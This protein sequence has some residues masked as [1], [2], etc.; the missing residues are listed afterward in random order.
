M[1]D[2]ASHHRNRQLTPAPASHLGGVPVRSDRGTAA[3]VLCGGASRGAMEV[4]FYRAL[5]EYGIRPDLIIGSSIGALNG[6]FIAGGMGSAEL[7]ELWNGFQLR[8]GF[9]MNWSGV[10]RWRRSPGLFS[11]DRLRTLLRRTLPATRFEDLRIPLTIVTTDLKSGSAV[12]WHGKGDIIEPIIASMSLPG[13]FPPVEI[14][15]RLHVDGSIADNVPLLKARELGASVVYLVECAC[16]ERCEQPPRGWAD[17]VM[18]SFSIAIDGRYAAELRNV[19][20]RLRVVTVR[21]QLTREVDLL[22]FRHSAELI[23]AAYQQTLSR[24]ADLQSPSALYGSRLPL[25]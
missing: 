15:G 7:A 17:V 18:R 13:L 6:A 4:G 8:Q 22:D 24:L 20:D 25:E 3:L 16:A 19:G 1:L 12:Y 5:T 14:E 11:L 21:P 9:G 2:D 23:D 10:T